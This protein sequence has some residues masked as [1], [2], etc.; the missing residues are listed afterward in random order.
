MANYSALFDLEA[1]CD[2]V[3]DD[4]SELIEV[5]NCQDSTCPVCLDKQFIVEDDDED[6][7]V[8]VHRKRDITESIEKLRLAEERLLNPNKRKN[9]L[10]EFNVAAL[11][12]GSVEDGIYTYAT[13]EAETQEIETLIDT[14][15][16]EPTNR[17][18]VSTTLTK[19]AKEG[20]LRTAFY[21]FALDKEKNEGA[22]FTDLFRSMQSE[23]TM[24]RMWGIFLEKPKTGLRQ[25]PYRS[26]IAIE[27]L[28][29]TDAD[30]IR[31]R[32]SKSHVLYIVEYTLTSRSIAG[33]KQLLQK[34]VPDAPLLIGVPMIK[35][36]QMRAWVREFTSTLSNDTAKDFDWLVLSTEG[37]L[38]KTDIKFN[39]EEML[40]YCETEKP[41]NV[42]VF[43][44]NYR[45]EAQLGNENAQAWIQMT[46][47]LTVARRTYD[48]WKSTLRGQ[49]LQLGLSEYIIHRCNQFQPGTSLKVTQLLTLNKVNELQFLSKLR[50][51]MKGHIKHNILCFVGP[52]NTG[53]SMLCEALTVVLGGAFLSWHEGNSFWKSPMVGV[54][55]CYLDDVT[56]V[57]WRHLDE[58]ERRTL[59]GG[60]VAINKKF[61]DPIEAKMPPCLLTTNDDIRDMTEFTYLNNRL[62]WVDFPTVISHLVVK[63]E[64]VATWILTHQSELDLD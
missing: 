6:E 7:D 9:L 56:R 42:E 55:S 1:D 13:T 26:H 27:A 12:G 61:H 17:D 53:K 35:K 38:T 37:P 63:A 39:A 21:H 41:Q 34:V 64:D 32:H 36:P 10:G 51:W 43:I 44:A 28:L 54:R 33:I 22:R 18:I 62:T 52:G 29:C 46:T 24:Q 14:L 4:F 11:E 60:V 58:R 50:K 8:N 5:C 25:G 16:P 40:V 57:I 20:L 45:K 19:E 15:E 47:A 48:L 2:D 49:A 31:A 59:D 23:K 30:K 3:D